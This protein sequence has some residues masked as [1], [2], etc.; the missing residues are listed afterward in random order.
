MEGSSV[1]LTC[2]SDANPAANYIWYKENINSLHLLSEGPQHVLRSIQTSDSGQYQ[3]RAQNMLG[4]S[5]HWVT[6]DVNYAPR[7]PSVSVS[8][9]GQIMEGSSVTLTC[10]SDANPAANYTW[11]KENINTVI[12]TEQNFTITNVTTEHGGNYQCEVQNRVGRQIT[13]K[14][15]VVRAVPLGTL[16]L[17][18]IGTSIAILLVVVDVSLIFLIRKKRSPRQVAEPGER[19]GYRSG[20]DGTWESEYTVVEYSGVKVNHSEP[21]PSNEV[22]DED[23]AALYSTVKNHCS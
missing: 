14:H 11:Y 6:I 10:S 9:P 8:P 12:S 1:T 13:T 18:V 15:L 5:F 21:R 4:T 22:T 2:S 17:V 7:T 20:R 3:C 19:P 16:E 23:T